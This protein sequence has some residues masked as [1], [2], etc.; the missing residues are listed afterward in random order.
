MSD[1]A[2]KVENLSK[3]YK[4]GTIG[5]GTL[6]AD[7]TR[8]WAS[9]RGKE[10]PFAQ[11]A[12][13]N[14]RSKKT[15]S[16]YVWSLKD[17]NFEIKK[18]DAVGI[19]GRNGAGKSTLLKILSRTTSPTTGSVKIGGRV[20]SLL[21]VGT[22]FHADLTGRE[23]VYM[24]G[25]ILG[26][27]RSEITAKL[28][29]IVEFSGVSAYVDT[30]VKR[31]SS[32]MYVRLAFAVSAYLDPDIMIVDEVLAVGDSVFQKKCIDKMSEQVKDG[33]TILFVSHNLPTIRSL[34][35]SGLLL[36]NGELIY[37]GNIQ[38]VADKYRGELKDAES[39]TYLLN[40]PRKEYIG[41]LLIEKII[42][43]QNPV[44][45]GQPISFQL[46][47]NSNLKKIFQDV[48][49]GVAI[50]DQNS[51]VAIH[52]SNRFVN[53]HFDHLSDDTLYHFKIDNLLKPGKYSVTLFLRCE[54]KIQDWLSEC[55]TLE[56]ADNN[57]YGFNDSKQI[58]GTYLPHFEIISI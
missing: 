34:C 22:G 27:T 45:Y 41:D 5:T 35:R 52:V 44:Q 56:I 53:K 15:D 51:H 26:M 6:S 11:V 4:L 16:Q 18:G 2:I 28:N 7:L 31:Y 10:D 30:P 21:E 32:G 37:K 29:D 50:N 23:N 8:W 46:K 1:I 54:D 47:L 38:E 49:F 43:S 14:D 42:F 25:A 9:V 55:L 13:A 36:Q 20:A 33:R 58:Q 57:P 19:I 24:N 12:V 48:D 17:I 3:L 40:I 39:E